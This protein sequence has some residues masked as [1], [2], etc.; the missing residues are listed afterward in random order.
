MVGSQYQIS[1]IFLKGVYTYNF[2]NLSPIDQQLI[3]A[4]GVLT[5]E[6]CDSALNIIPD[7]ILSIAIF[8]DE[9]IGTHNK[10]QPT[11]IW[12]RDLN[13][14]FSRSLTGYIWHERDPSLEYIP[15]KF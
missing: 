11:P 8:F 5:Y 13:L 2:E 10:P 14:D 1:Y 6:F 9:I 4:R 7:L 3:S 12:L 15:S